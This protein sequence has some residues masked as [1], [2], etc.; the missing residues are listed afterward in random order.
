MEALNL[1]DQLKAAERDKYLAEAKK[2][3]SEKQKTDFEFLQ[4]KSEREKVWWLQLK[5]RQSLISVLIGISFLGFYINYIVIPLSTID[6]LELKLNNKVEEIKLF[7]LDNKLKHD[8]ILFNSYRSST[9]KQLSIKSNQID[10]VYLL[11]INS[12]IQLDLLSKKINTD[13]IA[14][15][16]YYNSF[17]NELNFKIENLDSE[18]YV[19]NN[20]FVVYQD[21]FYIN[22]EY[23]IKN[24]DDSDLLASLEWMHSDNMQAMDTLGFKL[25]DLV[26]FLKRKRLSK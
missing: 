1:D 16:K 26:N 14:F 2:A 4:L 7:E 19:V 25:K 21:S 22:T 8:S 6:N 10:S 9:E 17:L 15:Y 3:E 20:N 12:K 5:F 24:V 23:L 13:S 18:L 11:N